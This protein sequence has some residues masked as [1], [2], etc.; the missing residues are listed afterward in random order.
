MKKRERKAHK[1]LRRQQK[2]EEKEALKLQIH[3]R[4]HALEPTLQPSTP[5]WQGVQSEAVYPVQENPAQIVDMDMDME[6]ITTTRCSRFKRDQD[7]D[8]NMET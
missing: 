2:R 1:Y 5:L 3:H 6:I 7:W 4:G 8:T